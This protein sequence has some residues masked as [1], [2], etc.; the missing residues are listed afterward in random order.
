MKHKSKTVDKFVSGE[1]CTHTKYVTL[2]VPIVA[3]W[4]ENP[5]G[6]H[7]H[8]GL[9]PGFAQWVKDPGIAVSCDVGCR[10]GSDL[11]LLCLWCRRAAVALI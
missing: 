3:Q 8:V 7:D 6:I 4:V 9:I 11:V 5:T 10:C 2:R 1:K